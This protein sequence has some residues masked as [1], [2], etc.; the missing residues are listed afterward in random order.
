MPKIVEDEKFGKNNLTFASIVLYNNYGLLC[1]GKVIVLYID[2]FAGCGGL[3]LGLH[4]AGL[5]GVF[6]VEKNRD[7]FTTVHR[8]QSSNF[9]LLKNRIYVYIYPPVC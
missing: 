5:K 7:A 2:L 3:S 4:N 9:S 1:E 6:A 8:K